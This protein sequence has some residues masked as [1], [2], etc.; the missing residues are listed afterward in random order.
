[1]ILIKKLSLSD[2]PAYKTLR[3][4]ALVSHPEAFLSSFEEENVLSLEA[5]EEKFK[6][7]HY[8]GVFTPENKLVGI[9]GFF[10]EKNFKSTH[11]GVLF[12]V[13]VQPEYRGLGLAKKLVEAVLDFAKSQVEQVHLTVTVG[14]DGAKKIYES[15]GFELYGVDP[16]AI[17]IKDQYFDENLMV[18]RF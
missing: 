5:W 18:L 14:N 3:L 12:S 2:L 4:E 16:M 13:Y 17:K 15:L 6:T 7:N 9:A 1:M 11:R 8:F 10:I